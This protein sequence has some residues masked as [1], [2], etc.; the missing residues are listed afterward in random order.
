MHVLDDVSLAYP[1][2]LPMRE[3]LHGALRAQGESP[4]AAARDVA[5]EAVPGSRPRLELREGRV[6]EV[7]CDAAESASLLVLGTVGLRPL[8]RVLVVRR[9]SRWPRTPPARWRWFARTR[10]PTTTGLRPGG[11]RRGRFARQ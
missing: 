8:G 3:D 11:G 5:R 7:L 9:R 10:A 6:A 2:P 4:L 1:R